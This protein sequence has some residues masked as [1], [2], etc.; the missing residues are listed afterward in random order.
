MVEKLRS[1]A[2][3][4]KGL[5]SLFYC[6][7]LFNPDSLQKEVVLSLYRKLKTD[8]NRS[9]DSLLKLFLSLSSKI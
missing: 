1:K 8:G 7:L 3:S 6:R 4:G 5:V 2:E 9:I